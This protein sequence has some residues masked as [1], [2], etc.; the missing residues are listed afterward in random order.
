MNPQIYFFLSVL[1]LAL[2]VIFFDRKYSMLRDVSV[3]DHKPYSFARVQLAWWSVIVLAAFISIVASR[4][5]PS[6]DTSTLILLGISSATIASARIA[7]LSDQS[8]PKVLR[9]QDQGSDGFFLDILSDGTGVSIH[10]FQTVVF[11]ITFGFWFLSQVFSN[12]PDS[13]INEIIPV[14]STNNLILLGLSS[15]TY[16]ALKT[17]ENK[18]TQRQQVTRR[19]T[20]SGN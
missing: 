5:I 10:R 1:V 13:D 11:N 6:L 19:Q 8:N 20:K 3:A 16:A 2:L 7:D 12:I 15:G 4:G 9:N 18:S 17:T 14:I